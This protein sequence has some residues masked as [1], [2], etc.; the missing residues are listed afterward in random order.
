MLGSVSGTEFGTQNALRT[1]HEMIYSA[2]LRRERYYQPRYHPLNLCS[3]WL[4]TMRCRDNFNFASFVYQVL[5]GVEMI[6]RSMGIS[7]SA[8]CPF[9]LWCT[10]FRCISPHAHGSPCRPPTSCWSWIWVRYSSPPSSTPCE[11]FITTSGPLTILTNIVRLYGVLCLQSYLFAQRSENHVR[12]LLVRCS[13][14]R[15]LHHTT[16]DTHRTLRCCSSCT[17]W[18]DM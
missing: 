7:D 6:L 14:G 15:S 2:S 16:R 5:G 1:H 18:L 10:V 3:D 12:S 13:V 9:I 4:L 17:S 8:F 11:F